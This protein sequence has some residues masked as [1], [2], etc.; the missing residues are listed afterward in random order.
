MKRVVLLL[1]IVCTLCS[2]AF[3]A[4]I[5]F[6]DIPWGSNIPYVEE[7]LGDCVS[8]HYDG[9]VLNTWEEIL[10]NEL[11]Y[12]RNQGGWY[13]TYVHMD[14]LKVGGY[15]VDHIDVQYIYGLDL[16]GGKSLR[17]E[18]EAELLSAEYTFDVSGTGAA[19]NDLKQKLTGLY[20]EGHEYP[21]FPTLFF[22]RAEA[23]VWYGENNAV[24]FLK[25]EVAP[26]RND[27]PLASN[28]SLLYMRTDYDKTILELDDV[29]GREILLSEDNAR[30]DSV[31]GL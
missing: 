30:N 3:A 16:E 23:T 2:G 22:D 26:D 15:D 12:N 4:E 28:L 5:L 9:A 6:R 18:N 20:G 13:G 1:L 31:D 21:N 27:Y 17:A 7:A 11:V 25:H 14:A 29:V 19:Y 24:A 8:Y 10:N